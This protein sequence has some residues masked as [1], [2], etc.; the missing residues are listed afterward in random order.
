MF[1][2]M[3]MFHKPGN[4]AAFEKD[5]N[6]FLGLVEKMPNILRRQVVDVV[7]SPRDKPVY[8][9]ILE[10]YF[11]NQEAMQSALRTQ[12]GQFAGASLARFPAGS[13]DL[14]FADVFEEE[15][16]QTPTADPA[17]SADSGET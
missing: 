9:R 12:E 4:L 8:Y 16:G 7:G 2:F 15:G 6:L 13:I 1:K 10:V 3:I 11:E 14:L 5:Y 17:S